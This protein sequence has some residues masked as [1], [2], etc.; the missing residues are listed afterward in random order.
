MKKNITVAIG[1]QF[2]VDSEKGTS[3]DLIAIGSPDEGW[4]VLGN[5]VQ[6]GDGKELCTISIT[7]GKKVWQGTIQDFFAIQAITEN[8]L[9]EFYL[10]VGSDVHENLGEIITE[11][12][13]LLSHFK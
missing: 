8:S 10:S 9:K 5:G 6:E 1:N 2:T 3:A 7:F 11:L 4:S 12:E 13:S